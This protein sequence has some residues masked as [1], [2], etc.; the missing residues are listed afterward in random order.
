MGLYRSIH[1]TRDEK[2]ITRRKRISP[3]VGDICT[4]KAVA[5]SVH[6]PESEVRNIE[7]R[8]GMLQSQE[9][10]LS[11]VIPSRGARCITQRSQRKPVYR[12]NG[13]DLFVNCNRFL[14]ASKFNQQVS[15]EL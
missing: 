6:I 3:L 1:S 15:V 10:S 11:V 7:R 13:Q 2:G 4:G 8:I 12:I 5:S 14:G 9:V